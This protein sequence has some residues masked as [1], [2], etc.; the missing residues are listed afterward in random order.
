MDRVQ[1]C[2]STLSDL[3]MSAAL[4]VGDRVRRSGTHT[5]GTVRW[6][7]EL[8]SRPA[9]AVGARR[10]NAAAATK[11]AAAP[12]PAAPESSVVPTGA[13]G[14]AVSFTV[15]AP[16]AAPAVGEP[17]VGVEWDTPEGKNDGSVDGHRY[18]VCRPRYGSL[19]PPRS[20][21]AGRSLAES[22]EA[23][24]GSST[25]RQEAGATPEAIAARTQTRPLQLGPAI[26]F[27]D[28]TGAFVK[29]VNADCTA[30]DQL[31]LVSTAG[32]RL[33]AL[34]PNLRDLSLA[35]TLFASWHEV[36]RIGAA[37]PRLHSLDLSRALGLGSPTAPTAP[38]A[39]PLP[40]LI[41]SSVRE[42]RIS[43]VGLLTP[44]CVA[45]LLRAFPEL[46]S[47]F[48]ARNRTSI[49]TGAAEAAS[50]SRDGGAGAV[51][52]EAADGAGA[53]KYLNV[54]GNLLR[55]LDDVSVLV[56]AL[57]CASITA[58]NVSD[59]AISDAPALPAIDPALVRAAP[60]PNTS[61]RAAAASAAA[62]SPGNGG[63]VGAASASAAASEAGE[64]CGRAV[65]SS[66]LPPLSAPLFPQLQSLYMNSVPIASWAALSRVMHRAANPDNLLD[67]HFSTAPT[68]AAGTTAAGGAARG[69]RSHH[70]PPQNHGRSLSAPPSSHGGD[71]ADDDGG[72]RADTG[73]GAGA[74]GDESFLPSDLR[75]RRRLGVAFFPPSVRKLNRSEVPAIERAQAL[76]RSV[77][78]F[79]EL[80]LAPAGEPGARASIDP[81][82]LGQLPRHL[83]R[84]VVAEHDKQTRAFGGSAPG[85]GVPGGP[86]YV[87]RPP[88]GPRLIENEIKVQL[89]PV[90]VADT[91]HM[92][93][94]RTEYFASVVEQ[95]D[96]ECSGAAPA[97]SAAAAPPQRQRAGGDPSRRRIELEI[98]VRWEAGQ[99]AE[100]VRGVLGIGNTAARIALYHIDRELSLNPGAV[101]QGL[102]CK[103]LARASAKLHSFKIASNDP[104]IVCVMS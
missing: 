51:A 90:F 16:A 44:Q 39:L 47:L 80:V 27:R 56:G 60:A 12:A 103:P 18:F 70:G 77:A 104:I 69:D 72:H 50:V 74:S 101:A 53:L 68:T 94:L 79:L 95:L 63:G 26:G 10:S 14:A 22:L 76:P 37:L 25:I 98:D 67:V 81:L 41:S 13:P 29:V 28:E 75:D 3:S 17:Y 48:A 96:A 87:F 20:L 43:D 15:P 88:P 19:L 33:G 57:R 73:A 82:R 21:V 85:D 61:P 64:G 9:P 42:L 78:T 11:A 45:W 36:A 4:V 92:R 100:T 71:D 35:G 30:N 34:F 86:G 89:A 62:T 99:L 49:G 83:Q 84:A 59:N 2:D 7:G 32:A 5:A 65:E 8:V 40:A 102:H 38:A 58:L 97:T 52:A 66:P 46:E 24:Y 93:R 23:R 1:S 31:G 54:E 6:V 55:S 91:N